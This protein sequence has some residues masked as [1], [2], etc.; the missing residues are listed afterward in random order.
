V[1]D[2]ASLPVTRNS[3]PTPVYKKGESEKGGNRTHP[4]RAI[5]AL[6]GDKP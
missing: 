1:H 4:T 3:P 5:Q 2:D 6:Y